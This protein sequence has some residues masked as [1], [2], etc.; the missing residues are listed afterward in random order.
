M[1]SH[2]IC[3]RGE[4]RKIL[5]GY[6]LLSVAM[7]TYEKVKATQSSSHKNSYVA[8]LLTYYYSIIDL[9]G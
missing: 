4:I 8:S 1:S 6:P 2:N 5:C 3:F 7:V 9:A